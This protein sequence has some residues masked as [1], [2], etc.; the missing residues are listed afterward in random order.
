MMMDHTGGIDPPGPLEYSSIIDTCT[1]TSATSARVRSERMPGPRV[2]LAL[3]R[4]G[5]RSLFEKKN[6]GADRVTAV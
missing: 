6:R 2:E 3:G 5:G 1:T 4:I